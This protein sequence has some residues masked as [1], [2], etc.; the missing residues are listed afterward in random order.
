MLLVTLVRG[1]KSCDTWPHHKICNDHGACGEGGNLPSD[2][3]SGREEGSGWPAVGVVMPCIGGVLV[4]NVSL[5]PPRLA[6]S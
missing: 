5:R 3:G 1:C 6:D 2:G 4:V